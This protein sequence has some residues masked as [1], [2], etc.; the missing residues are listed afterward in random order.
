MKS[1]FIGLSVASC[2][3]AVLA[4]FFGDYDL[5][6]DQFVW[7]MVCAL[8]A[9]VHELEARYEPAADEARGTL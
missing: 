6:H 9:R 2:L 3:I 8:F 5:A 1:W 7:T 4:F